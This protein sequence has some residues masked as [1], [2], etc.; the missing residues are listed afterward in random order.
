MSGSEERLVVLYV[1][2]DEDDRLLAEEALEQSS[3]DLDV[4]FVCD[5]A[6]ALDYLYRRDKYSSRGAAP[7]PSLIVL[8]LNMP[9]VDGREVLRQLKLHP[10]LWRIPVIILTTSTAESDIIDSYDLGVNTYIAKP[11]S[12][13]KLVETISIIGKYWLEVAEIPPAV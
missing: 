7:R 8:D 10:Q 9:K 3:A 11:A 6:E 12:F 5:G 2:D 1:E 13:D 4:R